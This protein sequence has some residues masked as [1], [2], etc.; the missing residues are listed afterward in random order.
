[1]YYIEKGA[2]HR[3]TAKDAQ[4]GNSLEGDTKMKAWVL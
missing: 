1:M 2:F 4:I 3:E